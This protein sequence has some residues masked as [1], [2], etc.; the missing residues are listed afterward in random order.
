MEKIKICE[1]CGA[2]MVEYKHIL[3]KGLVSA[4]YELSRYPDPMP[5]TELDITR[6]QWTNFQKLRYWG[7]VEKKRNPDGSSTGCWYVTEIGKRF[8]NN[9]IQCPKIVWTFRGEFARFEAGDI[10]FNEIYDPHYRDRRD[11]ARDAEFHLGV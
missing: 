10:Y 11:Y 1:C 5:L 4:L 3:N 2:K 6:N 8:I 7:L 9:Q